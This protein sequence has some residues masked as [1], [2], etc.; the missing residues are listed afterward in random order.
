MIEVLKNVEKRGSGRVHKSA[1]SRQ[2]GEG[3]KI[4]GSS[5]SSKTGSTWSCNHCPFSAE[6]GLEADDEADSTVVVLS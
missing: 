4:V 1:E 3:R 2:L 5:C 6:V